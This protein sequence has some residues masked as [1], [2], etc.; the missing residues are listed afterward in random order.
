M[1]RCMIFWNN[2]YKPKSPIKD[3]N[4]LTNHVVLKWMKDWIMYFYDTLPK[5]GNIVQQWIWNLTYFLLL[6][7]T[8]VVM[9]IYLQIVQIPSCEY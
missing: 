3:S 1:I 7:S 5:V 2:T 9:D 4:I 6:L 8:A